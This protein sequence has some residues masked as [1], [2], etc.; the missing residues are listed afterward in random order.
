M[1]EEKQTK[2]RALQ[3]LKDGEHADGQTVTLPEESRSGDLSEEE[4]AEIQSAEALQGAG[5]QEAPQENDTDEK[6]ET[7]N[8]GRIYKKVPGQEK[9]YQILSIRITRIIIKEVTWQEKQKEIT[10]K[11][12]HSIDVLRLV[13]VCLMAASTFGITLPSGRATTIY[14]YISQ[15]FNIIPGLLFTI[16]GYIIFAH[17]KVDY[18]KYVKRLAI[19]FGIMLAVYLPLTM[20]YLYLTGYNPLLLFNLNYLVEAL[21]FNNWGICGY[22]VAEVSGGTAYVEVAGIFSSIWLVQASLYAMLIL[23]GLS[24]LKLSDKKVV[25]WIICI[26]CFAFSVAFGELA[27]L[28]PFKLL[29]HNYIVGNFL[30]RA[31]P[32]MLLGKILQRNRNRLR[33]IPIYVDFLLMAVFG[34]GFYGEIWLLEKFDLLVYDAHTVFFI[35]IVIVVMALTVS[36]PDVGRI[37]H[38]AGNYNPVTAGI[39]FLYFPVGQFLIFLPYLVNSVKMLV[40]INKIPGIATMLISAVLTIA[41]IW[42]IRT[43]R[44]EKR[45]QMERELQYEDEI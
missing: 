19:T 20:L 31:L 1:S 2:D 13:A 43:I 12:C 8:T 16:Y 24:K 38:L 9:Q 7:K 18:R 5:G 39:Y 21:G 27:G 40:I 30:N 15:L 3:L 45:E 25:D 6:P 32:Y 10:G 26:L 34:A 33:N 29:G 44:K 23:W 22:L 41:T 37:K 14:N 28:M 36:F 17:K 4:T 11:Y 35:G 42:L